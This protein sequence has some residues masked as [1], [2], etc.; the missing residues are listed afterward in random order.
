MKLSIEELKEIL[1]VKVLN[2]YQSK[3]SKRLV[4]Y[5]PPKHG[6]NFLVMTNDGKFD[7][8]KPIYC[9]VLTESEEHAWIGDY[10]VVAQISNKKGAEAVLSL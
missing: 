7:D 5:N 4:A 6:I 10:D 9:T 1:E 8:K 3:E 2:F